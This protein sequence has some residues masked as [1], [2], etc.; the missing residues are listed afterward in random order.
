M[1][2][3]NTKDLTHIILQN[4]LFRSSRPFKRYEVYE[5]MCK[6]WG[7]RKTIDKRTHFFTNDVWISIVIQAMIMEDHVCIVQG[8]VTYDEFFQFISSVCTYPSYFNESTLDI[9]YTISDNFMYKIPHNRKDVKKLIDL[10]TDYFG[11]FSADSDR[12]RFN[13][14]A[15]WNLF[16]PSHTMTNIG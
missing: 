7:N 15:A 14:D 9:V 16:K 11:K 4:R 2:K 13:V 10:L 1:N 8:P 6:K 12:Y 3:V 5:H